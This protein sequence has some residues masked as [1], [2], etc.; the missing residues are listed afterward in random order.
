MLGQSAKEPP[1]Q[2]YVHIIVVREDSLKEML[3]G[4]G[5]SKREGT[6][7]LNEWPYAALKVSAHKGH[8]LAYRYTS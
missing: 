5:S 4:R 3:P 8:S 6:E 1:E 2:G 7:A